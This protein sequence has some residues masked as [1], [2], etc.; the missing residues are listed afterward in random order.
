M[1]NQEILKYILPEEFALHFDLINMKTEGE[2]LIFTLNEKN[3]KPPEH[4]DKKLESKGFVASIQILD[5]PIRDKGVI[6][7]V[8]RRKWKDKQTGKTYTRDWELKEKGTSY[9][10]EFAA[11][12]KKIHRQ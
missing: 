1:E 10:K 7:R 4:H 11:F 6:L 3:V 9:T 5:F 2:Q 12:L 8:R